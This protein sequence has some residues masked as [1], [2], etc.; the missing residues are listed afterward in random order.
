MGV[1]VVPIEI[2][3]PG[4]Q[5]RIGLDALVDTGASITAV[6]ASI[7]HQLGVPPLAK[8]EFEFAQGEVREMDVGQTW[9][10]VDGREVVTLVLFN[11]EGTQPL[12]GAMALE[13]VFLGVDPLRKRLI[14]IRGVIM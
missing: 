7:L 3:D 6:P 4:N 5:D 2:G 10:R 14:P 8:R 13:G 11:D 12:L 9:I 1:F